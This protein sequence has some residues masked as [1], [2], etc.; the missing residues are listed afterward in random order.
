L[1]I[2]GRD[3]NPGIGEKL[4]YLKKTIEEHFP[5]LW[6]PTEA[7]LSVIALLLIS[8]IVNCFLLVIV[9]PPACRKT[10]VLKWFSDTQFTYSSD[11]FTPSSFV[12]HF[13]SADEKELAKIDLLPRIKGKVLITAELLPIFD[14]P[15]ETLMHNMAIITRLL[16]GQGYTSDSGVHGRRGYTG[17]EGEYVFHWLGAIAFVPHHLWKLLG[18]MGPRIYFYQ[19][20][21]EVE[22][23]A[24]ELAKELQEDY[25]KKTT[26]CKNAVHS[27]MN[28]LF[29]CHPTK[30]EWQKE[31]DSSSACEMISNFAL[32]LCRLRGN[33]EI[34]HLNESDE[35]SLNYKQP[36]VEAPHRANQVLYNYARG[37]AVLNGRRH[38]TS[39]DVIL[40]AKVALN[41]A[42]TDRVR[43]FEILINSN[44]IATTK[45]LK[46]QLNCSTPTTIQ[47]MM[48]L[49][50]LGLIEIKQTTS[51]K[52]GGR[53]MK[54][55]SIKPIFS[56]ILRPEFKEIFK[57]R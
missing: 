6:K 16:D 48:A 27:Y 31:K 43:L 21:K 42:N 32:L 8:D 18:N 11:D 9:G 5:G 17:A 1:P 47:T 54:I 40:A 19:F 57:T 46:E 52:Q 10:T 30:I 23:D 38:I 34:G 26:I 49:K 20:P 33:V 55:A 3:F 37:H 53:P 4:Y 24:K 13:A 39:E 22:K 36:I 28:Y 41:S 2:V 14:A 50:I 51:G 44:G 25:K 45:Q 35:E 29:N 56:W 12:S 15:Y 7:C